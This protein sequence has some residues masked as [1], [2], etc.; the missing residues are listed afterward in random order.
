MSE[1]GDGLGAQGVGDG[2]STSP[3]REGAAKPFDFDPLTASV[4]NFFQIV[5]GKAPPV[6]LLPRTSV[7]S[8]ILPVSSG[9]N[10]FQ[11]IATKS[12]V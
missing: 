3:P 10:P 11:T 4:M 6:T 1:P 9:G 7:I 12:G 8:G 5:A 2:T